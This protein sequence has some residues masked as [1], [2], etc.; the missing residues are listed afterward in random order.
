MSKRNGKATRH[1]KVLHRSKQ[2]D[3]ALAVALEDRFLR[4]CGD[5][6]RIRGEELYVPS[7]LDGD[8]LRWR[9]MM[10]R[11]KKGDFRNTEAEIRSVQTIC[12]W[13]LE[14]KAMLVGQ[15]AKKVEWR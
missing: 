9:T 6:K 7:G 15:D 13:T 10:D 5:N 2:D 4:L 3:A 14:V 12:D 1:T 11:F 8:F